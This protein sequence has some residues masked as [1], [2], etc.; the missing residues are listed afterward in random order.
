MH[1]LLICLPLLL[2]LPNCTA[3]TEEPHLEATPEEAE[4]LDQMKELLHRFGAAGVAPIDDHYSQPGTANPDERPDYLPAEGAPTASEVLAALKTSLTA[5]GKTIFDTEVG[6]QLDPNLNE[7]L[8]A[9]EHRLELDITSANLKDATGKTVE[10][11]GS[12]TNGFYG[13]EASED[14]TLPLSGTVSVEAGYEDEYE[15]LLF[16]AGDL[17]KR[18]TFGGQ[19]VELVI[20]KGSRAVLFFPEGAPE[21]SLS[22]ENVNAAG[23]VVEGGP[24]PLIDLDNPVLPGEKRLV[25]PPGT[26]IINGKSYQIFAD[27]PDVTL[28]EFGDAIHNYVLKMLRDPE[29]A[30]PKAMIIDKDA[31][32]EQVALYRA[33]PGK[34]TTLTIDVE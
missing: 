14:I 22:A 13:L 30:R 19:P 25:K 5:R 11:T 12:S 10:L 31:N 29:T 20:L 34:K 1:R 21:G 23:Q 8:G 24:R 15:V 7:T 2:S 17:G 4:Q 9:D 26:K 3:Q 18:K 32:I 28:A 27:N 33:K 16:S 6:V